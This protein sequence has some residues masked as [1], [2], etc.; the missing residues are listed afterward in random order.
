MRST[1]KSDSQTDARTIVTLEAVRRHWLELG[2]EAQLYTGS[3]E[4]EL[5]YYLN[6]LLFNASL[7]VSDM[8]RSPESCNKDALQQLQTRLKLC[9][10]IA[11]LQQGQ[12]H[13]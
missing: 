12:L 2:L 7:I 10:E 1:C 3:A 9:S 6:T 11:R 5:H 13:E 4:E 8:D